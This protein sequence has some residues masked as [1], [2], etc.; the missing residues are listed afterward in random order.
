[1][2]AEGTS[3]PLV[4]IVEDNAANLLLARALL[5]RGGY[6]V[7][8]ARSAEEALDYLGE[9]LPDLV[10]MDIQLP[11]RDGLSLAREIQSNPRTENVPIIALTAN[12]MQGDRDL[13]LQAGCADYI[14]KPIDAREFAST[15]ARVLHRDG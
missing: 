7:S 14:A 8:E 9:A 6:R 15:I 4:L 13:C 11:G 1:M 2:T 5:R 12:A 10:L 3:D